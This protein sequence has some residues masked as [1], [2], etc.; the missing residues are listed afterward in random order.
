MGTLA[1]TDKV[2][3]LTV[4]IP[5]FRRAQF[6]P[7]AV[8]SALACAASSDIEVIV[9]PNGGDDSWQASLAPFQASAALRIVPIAR[10]N[11]NSAR[12]QGLALARGTY[13]RFLDDDDCLDTTGAIAQLHIIESSRADICSGAV[14]VMDEHG[15]VLR[16]MRQVDQED[17]F[18]AMVRPGRICLPT[19]HVFRRTALGNLRW[20]EELD[21]EQDTDWMFRIASLR[22]WHWVVVDEV[23][24]EWT[25]HAGQRTSGTITHDRRSRLACETIFQAVDRLRAADHFDERRA[26]GVAEALWEFAHANFHLA[27]VYWTRIIRIAKTYHSD[28][29][30]MDPFFFGRLARHID[31]LLIEWAMI[32]KRRLNELWRRLRL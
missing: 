27:P 29:G 8:A 2:P 6:L 25:Q 14:R 13:I 28:Y 12:N 19:A 16:I 10:A 24:G 7:R 11:A 30:P 23:V 18:I 9:V 32:P 1:L 22:H 21:V 4:V 5:T 15:Q 31:P 3:L 17:L 26:H 20:N